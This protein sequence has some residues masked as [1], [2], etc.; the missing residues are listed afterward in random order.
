[1]VI[2]LSSGIVILKVKINKEVNG[3]AIKEDKEFSRGKDITTN[4][5]F[6]VDNYGNYCILLANYHC[7]IT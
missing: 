4:V 2:F 6:Q 3:K 7:F 1:M 5:S